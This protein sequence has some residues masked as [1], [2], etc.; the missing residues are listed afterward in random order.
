MVKGKKCVL[1]ICLFNKACKESHDGQSIHYAMP[2]GGE[3][4]SSGVTIW[5]ISHWLGSELGS[6]I[7]AQIL[8]VGL[9]FLI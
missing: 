2:E 4:I 7:S 6:G 8:S 9:E 1:P 3:E 5:G